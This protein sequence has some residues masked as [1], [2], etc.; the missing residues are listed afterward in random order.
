MLIID[1]AHQIYYH[2]SSIVIKLMNS[3]DETLVSSQKIHEEFYLIHPQE[4]RISIKRMS[5]QKKSNDFFFAS[6]QHFNDI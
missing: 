2:Q 5:W 6:Q 3:F 4:N 1:R